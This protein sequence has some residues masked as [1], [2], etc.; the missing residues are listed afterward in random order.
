[1][2]GSSGFTAIILS[3]DRVESLFELINMIS[4]TSSIEKII[5]VWNNQFK[6]PPHCTY[7]NIYK[8]KSINY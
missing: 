5:V 8:K 7:L 1:M 2:S 6:S 3:Y 4:K